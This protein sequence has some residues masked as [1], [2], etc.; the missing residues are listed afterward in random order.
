LLLQNIKP[1]TVDQDFIIDVLGPNI[2]ESEAKLRV[3][4]PGVATGMAWTQVGGELLFIEAT[5]MPGNGRLQI[6]G[7]VK[8][9][10]RESCQASLSWLKSNA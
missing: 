2:F 7:N 9:V 3:T 8:D 6:T 10:M 5:Q 1:T 4:K